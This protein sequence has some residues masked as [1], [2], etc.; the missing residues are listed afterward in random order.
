MRFL[1]GFVS[2]AHDRCKYE[3][4]WKT[5]PLAVTLNDF[6]RREWIV[7]DSVTGDLGFCGCRLSN[8]QAPRQ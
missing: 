2:V 3:R 1:V 5:G 6:E 4:F 7:R 8:P